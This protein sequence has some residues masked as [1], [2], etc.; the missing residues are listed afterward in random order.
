MTDEPNQTAVLPAE[1][2]RDSV[3]ALTQTVTTLLED[4]ATLAILETALNS[5]DALYDQLAT[6]TLDTSTL[7]ALQRVEQFIIMQAG[8]YYQK[9]STKLDEQQS[10][11]FIALFARQLLNLDGV[12]PAT[13]RQLFQ[14]G[15]FTPENFFALT[16]KAIAQLQLPSA[17]LARL[18]PLHA[19]HQR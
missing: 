6:H 17:T 11:R 18:I 2:P 3:N 15:V 14:L 8:H 19:H 10:N 9:T 4:E 7:A 12:G 16:P 5:H 13:A 1:Q